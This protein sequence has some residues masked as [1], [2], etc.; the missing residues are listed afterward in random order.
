MSSTIELQKRQLKVQHSD[1]TL[2]VDKARMEGVRKR[3]QAAFATAQSARQ[4]LREWLGELR[5]IAHEEAFVSTCGADV[6][7]Q[8]M[9]SCRQ[10]DTDQLTQGMSYMESARLAE[11]IERLK[12]AAEEQGKRRGFEPEPEPE[13]DTEE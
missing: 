9:A 12:G 6:A 4:E 13:P 7:V 11:A 10:E 1:Q 5:L 3:N 8:D 2:L